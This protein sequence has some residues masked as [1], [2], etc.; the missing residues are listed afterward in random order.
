MLD[1][2]QLKDL[3]SKAD[4]SNL[5]KLFL[6]LAID[7]AAPKQ[8]KAVKEIAINAGLRS[9]TKWNVSALLGRSKGRAI[10]TGDGWELTADGRAYVGD[11]VG[12][13]AATPVTT[14]ASGLR[15]HLAG[16]KNKDVKAFVEEGI[17]CFERKLYRSAVVLT[18]VGAISL[19]Y[20][21]VVN[22]CLASFNAEASRRDAKW[23]TAKNADDLARM[24]EYDF[25]QVA[26]HL[27][28]FGRNVKLELEKQLK[29]RNACGHPNSLKLAE[30]TAAA[31]IEIL[32]LNVFS[33]FS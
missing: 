10:R 5:D 24:K 23:K 22:N 20:D 28:I 32:I 14:V 17:E 33:Q 8:V 26:E 19:L 7:N 18:W 11:L 3:L 12:P 27:S 2:T 4:F 16:I 1:R 31:H 25:L 15:V 13:I 30:Y 29:L 9:I 21:H 6:C